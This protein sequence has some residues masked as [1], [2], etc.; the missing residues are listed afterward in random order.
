MEKIK[1]TK[2]FI[3]VALGAF[4]WLLPS[5]GLSQS[6]SAIVV[7]GVPGQ[8]FGTIQA[9]INSLGNNA[10][11]RTINVTGTCNE[12]VTISPDKNGITL[13]GGGV[14]IINGQDPFT[15]N[16]AIATVTI[17]G[18]QAT[19]T[20][21]N[22]TGGIDGIRV[23]LGGTATV[24]NNIIS[25]TGRFGIVLASSSFANIVN[26]EI[27]GTGVNTE[28]STRAGI[29]LIDGCSAYIGYLFPYPWA[30]T[31]PNI[32]HD[33]PIGILLLRS[34]SARIVGNTIINNTGD[35]IVVQRASQA[36]IA[37]NL[38]DL[39]GGNGILVTQNSGV[40]LGNDTGITIFDLPNAGTNGDKGLRCSIGGYAD[41]RLGT[42]TGVG[43]HNAT[44]FTKD[45]IDSLIP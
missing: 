18:R 29:V 45:C 14:A 44:E 43:K 35:G 9:A 33:N 30:T 4:L 2:L 20:G 26:N 6:C 8:T 3:L 23:V 24:S 10:L 34:S 32:I 41:G 11:Y 37:D 15:P 7:G 21:F 40:N 25:N 22:I 28:H 19:I 38:I 31:Q 42:L 27:Y 13:N 39:N 1:I 17:L 36:D 16:L 5:T 12:S